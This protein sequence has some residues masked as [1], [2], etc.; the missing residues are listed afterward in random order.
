MPSVESSADAIGRDWCAIS[1]TIVGSTAI[2]LIGLSLL[3]RGLGTTGF[4]LLSVGGVMLL[5]A[6]CAA[7]GRCKMNPVKE[8]SDGEEDRPPAYR[9]SWRRSFLRRHTT[10]N[11]S[12]NNTETV[13]LPHITIENQS[14]NSSSAFNTSPVNTTIEVG[15]LNPIQTSHV[16]ATQGIDIQ[17][18][19][20]GYLADVRD[21]FN[22]QFRNNTTRYTVSLSNIL[23]PPP[24]EAAIANMDDI[25]I[26]KLKSEMYLPS[27]FHQ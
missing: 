3:I 8:L 25:S 17:Y 4:V 14:I 9:I 13:E 15:S 20:D 27:V 12:N 21:G 19:S 18:A 2:L 22:P 1:C 11:S 23:D 26:R 5:L 10:P 7:M 24:Y 6:T 16:P